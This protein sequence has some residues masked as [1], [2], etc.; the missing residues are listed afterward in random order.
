MSVILEFNRGG[1]GAPL[2][3]SVKETDR[4]GGA[5]DRHGPVAGARPL[6]ILI[7]ALGGEGGGVLLGWLVDCARAAGL[8]V[9]ATSVP[10]VAQRT[11]AT[12]YYLEV[13]PRPVGPGA[14]APVFALSPVAG[15]VDV[16]LASELLE[17]GRMIERGFVSAETTLVTSSSRVYTTLEKMHG[18][19]G[20]F[21]AERL[22]AAGRQLAKRHIAIDLQAL[23]ESHRTLI[24]ATLFGALAGSGVLPWPVA[25]CEEI[26]RRDGGARAAA[27]IAGFQ[28]AMLAAVDPGLR[29]QLERDAAVPLPQTGAWSARIARLPAAMQGNAT[30]AV[31]RLAR[32]QDAAYAGQYLDRLERLAAGPAHDAVFAEAARLLALW[33]SYEDIP[34]VAALKTAPGR[35]ARIRAEAGAGPNDLVHVTEHFKPGVDEVADM[36]PRALGAWLLRRIPAGTTGRG[37]HLPTTT[38]WGFLALRLMAAFGRARRAS[39]RFAREQAEIEFWLA[40]L[41]RA[42]QASPDYAAQLVRLPAL[43]RGYGETHARGLRVYRHLFATLV[44]PA[45]AGRAG[46]EEVTTL[47]KAIDAAQ[48]DPEG[49]ALNRT[50]EQSGAARVAPVEKPVMWVERKRGAKAG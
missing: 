7:A 2:Q 32:Y 5:V 25:L 39:L 44:E 16:V 38:V 29:A 6:S 9:Q 4:E 13:L 14:P 30:H 41:G 15:A 27:S 26:L 34:R 50:L 28:A 36:L 17:A 3:D 31:T 19:D 8:P 49:P 47:K 37:V 18:G 1:R 22:H 10:G 33:M 42:L 23:A 40:A 46:G 45:L 11:G 21:D 12:S 35:I 24:S 48:A 43:R 20:R